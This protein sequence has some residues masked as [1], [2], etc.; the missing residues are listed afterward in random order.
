MYIVYILYRVHHDYLSNNCWDNSHL[1]EAIVVSA[2]NIEMVL[3]SEPKV[4]IADG[5]I[6][7]IGCSRA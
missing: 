2:L 3:K 5:L 6:I 7:W 1:D 4:Y